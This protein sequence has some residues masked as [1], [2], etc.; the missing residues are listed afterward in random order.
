MLW[1]EYNVSKWDPTARVHVPLLQDYDVIT[2]GLKARVQVYYLNSCTLSK[3]WLNELLRQEYNVTTWDP[4]ARAQCDYMRC[5]A[6]V[7]I[8]LHELLRQE[9]NLTTWFPTATVSSILLPVGRFGLSTF[10]RVF[11][12]GANTPLRQLPPYSLVHCRR[13]VW[14]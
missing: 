7:R 9:Y 12:Q 4:T 2:G 10:S 13:K 14:Y 8:W 6:N 11:C 3:M 1:G 5:Y